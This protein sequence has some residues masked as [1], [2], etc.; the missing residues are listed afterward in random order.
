MFSI[1][2]FRNFKMLAN[3]DNCNF[4]N[5]PEGKGKAVV[6]NIFSP[7]KQECYEENDSNIHRITNC[8]II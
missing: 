5:S 3:V 8:T 2:L 7:D 6:V 4:S 1:F